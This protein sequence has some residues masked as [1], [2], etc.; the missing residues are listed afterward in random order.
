VAT[1]EA[2]ARA[3]AKYRAKTFEYIQVRSRK[4][5]RMGELLT[6]AAAVSGKSKAQYILDAIKTQLAADKISV[7]DLP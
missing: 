2:Q 5:E 6:L 1:T 3:N 7:D 4:T